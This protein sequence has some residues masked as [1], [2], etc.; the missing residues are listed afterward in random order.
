[1]IGP[2]T[3]AE[4]RHP[5][6]PG[7]RKAAHP[8]RPR[9]PPSHPH[10]GSPPGARWT[11]RLHNG[12]SA[13]SLG[14]QGAVLEK[15][16]RLCRL[17][18][19]CREALEGP[20]VC[21]QRSAPCGTAWPSV[22]GSLVSQ[23]PFHSRTC[24]VGLPGLA[25]SSHASAAVNGRSLTLTN[26]PTAL[27]SN[28]PEGPGSV[29]PLQGRPTSDIRRTLKWAWWCMQSQPVEWGPGRRISSLSSRSTWPI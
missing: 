20:Q 23:D 3:G 4:G 28:R 18:H 22:S 27:P 16:E 29:V 24:L 14:I 12:V 11:P 7:R 10:S 17:T 15:F 1:M 5:P 8:P 19:V 26:S 6:I 25:W 13:C 21:A 2:E 9:T